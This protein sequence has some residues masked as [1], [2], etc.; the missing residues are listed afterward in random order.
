[1]PTPTEIA[2]LTAAVAS[3]VADVTVVTPLDTLGYLGT[4]SRRVLAKREDLQ[5]TGSFKIRGAAAKLST[6]TDDELRKGVIAASTGNH[7]LAV[8]HAAGLRGAL[9]AVYVPEDASPAKLA[10]IEQA[11]GE[12][13]PVPGNAIEAERLARTDAMRSGRVY[14]SPYNDA[15]VVAGQ[16]TIG[17]ELRDQVGGPFTLVVSV[18]GGG[19]VSGTAATLSGGAVRVVGTSPQVDA[20][21]AASIAA[22]EVVD[23]EAT[24]TLSDGTAGNL[25]HDT[26]TFDLCRTLVDEWVLQPESAIAAAGRRHASATGVDV[27]GSAALALATAAQID[28]TGDIVVIICGGNV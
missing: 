7:G 25:E 18:G 20:A 24:P 3:A 1:V 4:S 11:G 12:V 17:L 8:S 9:A 23:V 10:K 28:A 2:Q 21:M 22:G 26:I 13:V 5:T 27:E 14:I 6:L 19:L 15:A 16:G